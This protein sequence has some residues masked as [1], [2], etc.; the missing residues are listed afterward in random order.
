MQSRRKKA[1]SRMQKKQN[2]F[3]GFPTADRV[4]PTAY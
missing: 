4:L 1:A 2:N 3:T